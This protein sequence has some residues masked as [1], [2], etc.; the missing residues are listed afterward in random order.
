MELCL[1][2]S[3]VGKFQSPEEGDVDMAINYAAQGTLDS[4]DKSCCSQHPLDTLLEEK[5]ITYPLVPY[6]YIPVVTGGKAICVFL[7]PFDL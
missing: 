4:Q 5:E 1:K 3:C 6:P 2:T 7:I